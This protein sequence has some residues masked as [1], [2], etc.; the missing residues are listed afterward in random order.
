MNWLAKRLFWLSVAAGL[1]AAYWIAWRAP[2][3]GTFHDD[4]IYAV[5]AKALAEGK[6]YRI[7][8]L[9]AEIVQTKYPILFP[10]A[11]AAVWKLFPEFPNN[12]PLL[13]LVPLAFALLWLVVVYR[14]AREHSLP[15]SSAMA[16]CLVT[17]AAPWT[18]YL[19]TA[20]LSETLF[21][22]CLTA[23]L[24]YL[25]QTAEGTG[26]AG[27]QTVFLSALFA[28]LAF[29][30]RS[31]GLSLILAGFLFLWRQGHPRPAIGFV[32][33]AS[34]FSL[35]W[36]VWTK[37]AAGASAA[38]DS[39][40]SVA[41]YQSWN[42]LF[43]FDL[44]QKLHIAG[45]NILMLILSP[46]AVLG[47]P[48]EGVFF[49]AAGVF[50]LWLI[51]G[52]IRQA[53]ALLKVFLAVYSG[54][55]ICWAWSPGR[56]VAPV[57]PLLLIPAARQLDRLPGTQRRVAFGL[58]LVILALS[59]GAASQRTLRL[60]DAMPALADGDGFDRLAGLMD[61]VS[62]RT[63]P[64]SV[65]AGNLDP[66]YYLYTGRKAVRAF[67]ADPYQLIYAQRGEPIGSPEQL[68]ITLCR[69]GASY[70]IES[71]N[72][73]FLEGKYLVTI[74]RFLHEHSP[75]RL[76]K[77]FELGDRHRVYGLPCAAPGPASQ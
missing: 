56:F 60:G 55:V 29:L 54:F 74:Q 41:N 30:T 2:A 62:K 19:S 49:A 25:R 43:N 22:L 44:P 47:W 58:V 42:I 66:L 38:A 64:Q 26:K 59:L 37:L 36:L 63:S 46:A 23:S 28:A 40:Y 39:Y 4:G 53:S 77:L 7:L 50:G 31:I 73:G 52:L 68:L 10:L 18:V 51:S 70:W 3:V 57:L 16:V 13:K 8:S 32:L 61:W 14:F 45:Q 5:T 71:P 15:R 75:Q 27:A 33:V 76:P 72:S 69:A 67:Q 20:L 17:A 6:G 1:A 21:A 11:L 35:P 34:L 9:P 12:V 24:L 65:L 48:M